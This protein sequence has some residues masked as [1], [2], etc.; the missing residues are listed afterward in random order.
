MLLHFF[1]FFFFHNLESSNLR[2]KQSFSPRII[3]CFCKQPSGKNF[4]AVIS[5]VPFAT[6]KLWGWKNTKVAIY[7]MEINGYCGIL[8]NC[9]E[10]E[11]NFQ[12]ISTWWKIFFF[13]KFFTHPFKN[14]EIIINLWVLQNQAT[15]HIW[16]KGFSIPSKDYS[17]ERPRWGARQTAML[18]HLKDVQCLGLPWWFSWLRLHTSTAEGA[19]VWSLLRE[20]R[21]PNVM[22][23]KC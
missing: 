4:K 12:I 15:G 7:S 2:M 18:S 23:S 9:M 17:G 13:F 20:L 21:F 14:L 6:I 16:L 10:T 3:M 22:R 8:K 5:K 11:F 1:K 19:W